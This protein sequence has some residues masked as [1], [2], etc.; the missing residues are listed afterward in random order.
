MTDEG[1]RFSRVY[2]VNGPLDA[3]WNAVAEGSIVGQTPVNAFRCTGLRPREKIIKAGD[4][5]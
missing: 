1:Q 2:K 5:R 3:L 4:G